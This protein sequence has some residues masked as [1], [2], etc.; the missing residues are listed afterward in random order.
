MANKLS[1]GRLELQ[2][3]G[4][5]AAHMQ[6]GDGGWFVANTEAIPS[7]KLDDGEYHLFRYNE[8]DQFATYVDLH[9]LQ[10]DARDA[11]SGDPDQAGDFLRS[12]AA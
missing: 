5:W 8:D 11:L 7:S 6:N 3:D 10:G 2:S 4:R 1:I 9:K 12:L